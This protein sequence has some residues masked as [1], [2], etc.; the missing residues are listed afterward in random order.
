MLQLR[1]GRFLC[2]LVSRHHQNRKIAPAA[3]WRVSVNPSDIIPSV[4]GKN[5]CDKPDCTWSEKHRREC[6][7]RMVMRW[8]KQ[9]RIEYYALVRRHRGDLA[10][11]QLLEEVRRQYAMRSHLG[12]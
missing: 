2:E 10:A 12:A 4:C 11:T 5:P 1:V 6:E 7:A 9:R 3:I 8:S